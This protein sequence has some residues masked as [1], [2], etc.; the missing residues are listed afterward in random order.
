MMYLSVLETKDE[1]RRFQLL[2]DTYER[3]LYRVAYNILQEQALAEEALQE[4]W[5]KIICN[6][7]KIISISGDKTERY[8]VSIVKN[9]SLTILRK[10][11]HADPLPEEWELPPSNQGAENEFARLVAVIRS[12]PAQYRELLELKF[13]FEWTNKELAQHFGMKESTVASRIARGRAQL[14]EKLKEEGYVYG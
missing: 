5:R 6:F 2:H 10:E 1:K 14:I 11:K 8:L 9:T 3:K 4:S 12:M 7:E 13:V